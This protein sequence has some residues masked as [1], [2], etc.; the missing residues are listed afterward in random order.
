[1]RLMSGLYKEDGQNLHGCTGLK[2]LLMAVKNV[3]WKNS[4]ATSDDGICHWSRQRT[5]GLVRLKHSLFVRDVAGDLGLLGFRRNC[6]YALC[7]HKLK[8]LAAEKSCAVDFGQLG[9]KVFDIGLHTK[10]VLVLKIDS[11][12]VDI[13][14]YSPLPTGL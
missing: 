9:L 14:H 1:M 13:A 3:M 10:H 4:Y 5:L 7:L 6:S 2:T 12:W 11:A 8:Q